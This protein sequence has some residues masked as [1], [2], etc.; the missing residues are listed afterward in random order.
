MLRVNLKFLA[1][2]AL[3]SVPHV[4][5]T[6]SDRRDVNKRSLP[7]NSEQKTILNAHNQARSK[8]GAADMKKL[9]WNNQ[10]QAAA[11]EYSKQCVWAHGDLE[12]PDLPW[13]HLGQNLYSQSLGYPLDLNSVVSN[14]YSE[15]AGYDF[16]TKTCNMSM[17]GHYT[18]VVWANTS[19]VGCACNACPTLKPLLTTEKFVKWK[20]E[21]RART[22]AN[23]SEFMYDQCFGMKPGN[24]T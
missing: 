1:I 8:E 24:H 21:V 3:W 12:R 4:A 11:D 18:Q 10:L 13:V 9:K 23:E 19:E 17:C 22:C 5:S 2:V 15:K 16:D 14:W 7:S 20:N 6:S